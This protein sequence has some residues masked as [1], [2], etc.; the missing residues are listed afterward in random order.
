MK[1]L[2]QIRPILSTMVGLWALLSLSVSVN[3]QGTNLGTGGG[4]NNTFGI[5]GPGF[6]AC[7]EFGTYSITSSGNTPTSA[8]L[9]ASWTVTSPTGTGYA[10]SGTSIFLNFDQLGRWTLIFNG[11]L[12]N[13][14]CIS[15]T[16]QVEVTGLSLAKP[17]YMTGEVNQCSYNANYTYT[18]AP[19]SN[20]FAYTWTA[21]SPWKLVHPTT[22]ALATTLTGPWT[23]MT[24]RSPSSG[25]ISGNLTVQAVGPY[26]G[27]F[28]PSPVIFRS[29]VLGKRYPNILGTNQIGR[30]AGTSWTVGGTGITNVAW[31][32][33]NGWTIESVSATHVFAR[34]DG[35]SG[36]V[37]LSYQTC[38]ET[39]YRGIYV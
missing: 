7:Q 1:K 31:T 36:W 8:I 28:N 38:G 27:C 12:N 22:G 2:V 21:P 29:M 3:A 9:F 6:R 33:P 14:Q 16:K 13:G 17:A 39:V 25:N 26:G 20:A 23:S 10:A 4:C 37:D 35:N 24:V 34:N 5:N 15:T 32:V 11:T 18:V 19:V 30:F